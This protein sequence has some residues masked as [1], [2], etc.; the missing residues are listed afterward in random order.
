MAFGYINKKM[1][2]NT[3]K[4]E[5]YGLKSSR[6]TSEHDLEEGFKSELVSDNRRNT[7]NHS[8]M[9]PPTPEQQVDP[10]LAD[11]TKPRSPIAKAKE[12]DFQVIPDKPV[13]LS[14]N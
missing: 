4:S 5:M 12:Q 10:F 13:V 6:N 7:I 8:T 14:P 11:R 2:N 1:N 9:A 3:R